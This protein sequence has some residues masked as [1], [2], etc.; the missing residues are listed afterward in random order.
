MATQELNLEALK[1]DLDSL[2]S[3]LK[4]VVKSIKDLGA[5]TAEAGKDKLLDQLNSDEIKKYIADLKAKGKDG[6]E[7]VNDTIKE[8]PIKSVA[9]AAGI[10]FLIGW[11]LKR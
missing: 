10:G 2:K 1:K 6:I 11:I 3:D 8:D 4:D 9:M 5:F 7:T